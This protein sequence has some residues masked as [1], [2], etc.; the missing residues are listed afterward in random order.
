[1]PEI[2]QPS[3]P[4]TGN[5]PD[6]VTSG[7]GTPKKAKT[8]SKRVPYLE[9]TDTDKSIL[10]EG[11]LTASPT[12]YEAKKHLP[13]GKKDFAEEAIYWDFQGDVSQ[14]RTDLCKSNAHECRTMGNA[15]HRKMAKKRMKMK[16]ALKELEA[17]LAAQGIN[18]DD[19]QAAAA[20]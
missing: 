20:S 4:A 10:A 17:K 19:L 13:P 18:P 3:A 2:A 7:A 9:A 6:V 14:A 12:D 8:K 5:T 11:K 1:M 15:E 16:G